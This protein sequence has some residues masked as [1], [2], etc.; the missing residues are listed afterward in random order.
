MALLISADT[1][2]SQH[3]QRQLNRALS[4]WN[5]M[6]THIFSDEIKLF[7]MA[8]V[9]N[10]VVHGVHDIYIKTI[11]LRTWILSN[12]YAKSDC[13]PNLANPVVLINYA[14]ELEVGNQHRCVYFH[15]CFY[16][17][18]IGMC[19]HYN[20]GTLLCSPDFPSLCEQKFQ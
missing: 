19:F 17:S 7:F 13:L 3:R 16:T 11:P 4:M 5:Q 6:R 2:E 8:Y 18:G 15:C 1:E 14:N 20:Q 12:E 9:K 10:N